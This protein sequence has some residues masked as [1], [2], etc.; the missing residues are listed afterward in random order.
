[1]TELIEQSPAAALLQ[2]GAQARA[3]S[4]S[5]LFWQ[6]GRIQERFVAKPPSPHW[7]G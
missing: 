7:Q 5:Q 4:R 1:M 2:M 3:L 6:R